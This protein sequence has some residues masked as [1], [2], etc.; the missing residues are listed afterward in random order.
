MTGGR[1]RPRAADAT[2]APGAGGDDSAAARNQLTIGVAVAV[3]EPDATM[4][5][6]ARLSYGDEQAHVIPT[7]VTILPPTLVDADHLPLVC[8]HLEEVAAQT[9]PFDIELLGTD[10]FRPVSPVVFVP[11][12]RGASACVALAA[13]VRS[14]P[15]A[16]DLAFSYHPHVTLGHNIPDERLD[17]AERDSRGVHVEFLAHEIGLYLRHD[18][19]TWERRAAFPFLG[20]TGD[21][22]S[23][24]LL[25]GASSAGADDAAGTGGS[26]S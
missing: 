1:V 6:E 16:R 11:L 8:R 13:L 18:D 7:H 23:L 9:V 19:Q 17:E 4:L 14:G 15:L 3:P 12:M 24:G 5:R 26:A 10:S 25:G 21:V 22:L 20:E 2:P